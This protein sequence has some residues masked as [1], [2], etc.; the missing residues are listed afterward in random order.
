[1]PI[2]TP[3]SW[4]LDADERYRIRIPVPDHHSARKPRPLQLLG[5]IPCH[6]LYRQHGSQQVEARKEETSTTEGSASSATAA[7]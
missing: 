5:R 4:N 3:G 1:T 7:L 6:D 2:G